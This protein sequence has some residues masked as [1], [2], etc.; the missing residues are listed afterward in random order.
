MGYSLTIYWNCINFLS[1]STKGNNQ[2]EAA[3]SEKILIYGKDSWPYTTAAR[4]AC[5]KESREVEYY[6]VRFDAEK[7]KDMLKYSDGARRVPV[8]VD[9]G[10]VTIGFNGKTWGVW[11]FGWELN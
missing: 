10:K 11:V 4:A 9:Q 5:T 2:K 1:D 7:M 6:D 3:V 8:I